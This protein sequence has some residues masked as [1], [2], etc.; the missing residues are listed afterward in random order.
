MVSI[1][2]ITRRRVM[3]EPTSSSSNSSSQA[4]PSPTLPLAR[5]VLQILIVLNWGLCALILALLFVVP[6][7]IWVLGSFHIPPPAD[8]DELIMGM[9]GIAVCGLLTIPLNY[10]ILTRLL[11]M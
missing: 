5:G 2:D 11:A 7:R 1:S 10:I 9:R 8:A 6:A 3:P 4:S